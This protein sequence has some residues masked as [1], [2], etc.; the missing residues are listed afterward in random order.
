MAVLRERTVWKKPRA[1][2]AVECIDHLSPEQE[3]NVRAAMNVLRVRFGNWHAVGKAMRV[4]RQKVARVMRGHGR[5]T[6]G[7]AV[8][9]AMLAG[10]PVDDVL[11]GAFPKPGSC[12]MCGRFNS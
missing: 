7:L 6:A 2:R 4:N 3:A 8:R 12:P 1:A 11:S 9:A 10:V 5:V